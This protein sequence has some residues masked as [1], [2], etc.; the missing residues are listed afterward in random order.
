MRNLF[1]QS[2]KQIFQ[3]YQK[4]R[5]RQSSLGRF[6]R[7]EERALLT[8]TSWATAL[9]SN[10][11][12]IPV[13]IA[14]TLDG[15]VI[16]V[17]NTNALDFDKQ[18]IW[19]N[20]FDSA[21]GLVWTH[22]Y[23]HAISV[24]LKTAPS[25]PAVLYEFDYAGSIEAKSDGSFLVTGASAT[26]GAG[27]S[28]AWA[29]TLDANGTV[30]DDVGNTFNATSGFAASYN[31]TIAGNAT[32][33]MYADAERHFFGR[34]A[35]VV[36]IGNGVSGDYYGFVGTDTIAADITAGG[37]I[38]GTQGVLNRRT[39]V[40]GPGGTSMLFGFDERGVAIASTVGGGYGIA[41][42]TLRPNI[43]V[44]PSGVV[45]KLTTSFEPIWQISFPGT[46]AESILAT[47]D[48]GFLV[49]LSTG[50]P[51]ANLQ[52]GSKEN[53]TLVKLSAGGSIE[54]AKSYGGRGTEAGGNN[55][56]DLVATGDGYIF[57][58]STDSFGAQDSITAS[59]DNWVVKTDLN[60][61]VAYMTGLYRDVK[62]I[63]NSVQIEGGN[64]PGQFDKLD[65]TTVLDGVPS[66]N[67]DNYYVDRSKDPAEFTQTTLTY[68]IPLGINVSNIGVVPRMQSVPA[69]S[70]GSFQ[71]IQD[72]YAVSEG[73][74]VDLTV[75]RTSGSYGRDTV[76]FTLTPNGTTTN[77][78]FS[79]SPGHAYELSFDDGELS[80]TIRVTANS[81]TV[82]DLNESITVTLSDT[83]T[84]SYAFIGERAS[85]TVAITNTTALPGRVEF[86]NATYAVDENGASI[87]LT[88]N[89][90]DASQTD[91]SVDWS[92]T[93][94]TATGGAQEATGV[95]YLTYTAGT[96]QFFGGNTS[97]VISIP[98][99][100]DAVI[101]GDETIFLALSNPT[102]GGVLATNSTAVV[103]IHDIEPV[104]QPIQPKT[105]GKLAFVREEDF[106]G[107]NDIYVMNANG[108]GI[109][110]L[111]NTPHFIEQNPAWSSDG[112][113]LVF[114]GFANGGDEPSGVY[115]MN[116]NGSN[117]TLVAVSQNIESAVWSPDGTQIAYSDG[118][119]L[120]ITRAG[121]P[122]IVN[123]FG[124]DVKWSP[125]STR[126]AFG[127]SVF[128][129]VTST[130]QAAIFDVGADGFGVRQL[131]TDFASATDFSYTP[132]G[133][134]MIFRG[135]LAGVTGIYRANID[136]SGTPTRLS[137]VHDDIVVSPD[138]TKLLYLQSVFQVPQL[139]VSNLN[140][141]GAAAVT[142]G[143][144][145][146]SD[147]DWQP[148][149]VGGGDMTAPVPL[150]VTP[151]KTLITDANTGT[152]TFI[153]TVVFDEA[154]NTAVPPTITFP[155]EDPAAT[156]TLNVA[157]SSWT[158]STTFVAK[159]NVSDQNIDLANVD[160]RV[161]GAKDVAGNTQTA[162]TF[163]NRFSID[164]DPGSDSTQP[165]VTRIERFNPAQE[166]NS[167]PVLVFHVTFSE[168]INPATVGL[169]SFVVSGG[170]T[171]TVSFTQAINGSGDT[172]FEVQVSGGNIASFTGTI[173]LNISPTPQVLDVAGN[174][175]LTT[176]PPVDQTYTRAGGASLADSGT[177][178]TWATKQPAVKVFPAINV[179]GSS[180]AGA[181]LMISIT[182]ATKK[183]PLQSDSIKGLGV[184]SKPAL[185]G[186]KVVTQI[187]L[188]PTAT[189]SAV[190]A[191]LRSM[192]FAGKGKVSGPVVLTLTATLTASGN[193]ST[194]TKTVT[195][196]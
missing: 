86:S 5:R 81:D 9:G 107:L 139:F 91:M 172:E 76:H 131:F 83:D 48:G 69:Y 92:F 65:F 161:T 183:S 195:R 169:T 191:F 63:L 84:L 56:I 12:D 90:L 59:V 133:T 163:T 128:D 110:N 178:V 157:Q 149:P 44:P 67:G 179:S 17:G 177:G 11:R 94:G 99:V 151:N 140:G 181:T 162:V 124:T 115:T 46:E 109:V 123:V 34:Y 42:T 47:P 30:L 105:N 114:V 53:V 75:T 6:E 120:S 95:D 14:A 141:S 167:A 93:G 180:L 54:W 160:V 2:F 134:Q 74:F 51:S 108:T 87:T 10:G 4:P 164:M 189:A 50:Y 119:Q 194:V 25:L 153:L 190:Q 182:S 39:I 61:D 71:F 165:T 98:I 127:R 41:S 26:E 82:V 100:D 66:V 8:G 16:V 73:D 3:S 186:G 80:K 166:V 52:D 155:V 125:D 35:P 126:I 102:N 32:L 18:D 104:A 116:A 21:G 57:T 175:L 193:S 184:A 55:K 78:D 146:K 64:E 97:L 137:D 22:V 168:A 79:P 156:L 31:G 176:E 174:L 27:G 196:T 60:G 150:N 49:A 70:A 130:M 129:E 106:T 188:G 185:S 36:Y 29:M 136:G 62:S 187:Q 43:N 96:L 45:R 58:T 7:L 158:N 111:T 101:E 121:D 135:N 77:A 118:V 13:S 142:V 38:V 148:L 72:Q 170:S 88:V 144:P 159:Y 85:T 173:G 154:M 23:D 145:A 33:T 113:K 112:S 122:L 37:I 132:D 89:R 171:A 143:V 24:A 68:G 147:P 20:R 152:S 117:R 1:G 40:G 15:G 19:V 103:T 192:T 28:V 138:G